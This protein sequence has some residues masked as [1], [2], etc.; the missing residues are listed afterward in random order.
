MFNLVFISCKSGVILFLFD[1]S[2]TE[3]RNVSFLVGHR[4]VNVDLVVVCLT[5]EDR[6]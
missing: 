4:E 5:E 2:I 6:S 3:N 1:I